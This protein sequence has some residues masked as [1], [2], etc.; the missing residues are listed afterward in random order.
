[1]DNAV[2]IPKLIGGLGNQLFILASAMDIAIRCKRILIL[3]HIPT[4]C[5]C[6]EDRPLSALFPEIP[7]RI[8]ETADAEYCGD[9]YSYI[10]IAPRINPEQRSIYISG[11][12]QHSAYIPAGFTN[13]I[14][15]IPDISPYIQRSDLAFLHVRRTDYVDHPC[16][17]CDTD[18]YYTTAVQHLLSVNP[19]IKLLI[20]SD[21][22]AWSNPYI[23]ALLAPL[24]P[25]DR[26]LTL[27]REYSATETLKIMANCCGGAICANSSFSWWGAY[28]NRERPIY[29]PHPW[30]SYDSSPD[31]GIY[32]K[33]VHQISSSLC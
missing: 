27:D 31:L 28:V 29:M 24:L 8:G 12:N 25:K 10:D 22:T 6:P 30:S 18:R 14:N 23:Q 15:H 5:H 9:T 2:V 3:N 13:F 4:N 21:D 7:V 19:N 32:F 1:M 20:V 17:P 16:Y 11:Y 33:G 26:I